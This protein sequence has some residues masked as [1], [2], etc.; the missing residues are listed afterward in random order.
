MTL[1]AAAAGRWR[2]AGAPQRNWLRRH[3]RPPRRSGAP[4]AAQACSGVLREARQARLR[5]LSA[6]PAAAPT[7]AGAPL[8]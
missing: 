3:S 6:A 2:A 4:A 8:S 5:L 7:L 1:D